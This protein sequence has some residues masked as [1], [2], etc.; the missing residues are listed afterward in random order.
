MEKFG[1]YLKLGGTIT[2]A[3]PKKEKPNHGNLYEVKI[4]IG[5]EPNGKLKRKSFYS[6]ISKSDAKRK[7]EEW[8]I[9]S[10][11]AK[12]SGEIA[13]L[14][15]VTFKDWSLKWLE[16]YK[17]PNVDPNTY[18]YTYR[19]NVEK[20]LLPYFGSSKLQGISP[21]DVQSFFNT[22]TDLS[23]SVLKKL[24]MCLKSIFDT[25]I[26]N[27]LCLKN[28]IKN[29]KI[30]SE[31]SKSEKQVY[32]SLQINQ[33]K[34]Y[35][36]NIMPEVAVL[37]ETGLRRGELLGLMWADLDFQNKTLSVNRSV[38]DSAAPKENK[39]RTVKINPPKWGSYRIIPLTDW[40]L[41]VFKNLPKNSEYIF[42]GI[43]GEPQS[44]NT[45]S[46][47]L[48][49]FMKS[50][51]IELELPALSAHELRHTYGTDLRRKDVDIYT[52][53]KIMGHKDI[54]MTSEIYVHNEIEVLRTQLKHE[55]NKG[56]SVVQVSYGKKYRIA[57]KKKKPH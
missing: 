5:K 40:C 27:D 11:L 3:R 26:D 28:P 38:A 7:A 43:D 54:K 20:H 15:G 2:V 23:E 1:N 42:P 31:A 37:L 45:W 35:A 57:N 25:A 47:K 34:L 32:D 10:A 13:L 14:K 51:E 22:K 49:R 21:V 9:E 29:I 33:I 6:D 8:K 17:K 36:V 19:I 4:T 30:K 16:V 46:Q 41:S 18:E 12:S 50:I 55:E 24:H 39:K 56:T 48:K 44:P 53:Q 52:I